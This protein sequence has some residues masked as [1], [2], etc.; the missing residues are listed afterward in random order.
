MCGR[1]ILESSPHEVK[2]YFGYDETPNFPPRYNI[3][4]TQPIAVIC[5]H[6]NRP[7]F[8]LMKW[9]FLPGWV[10]DPKDFPL[11]INARSETA[12]EKPAFRAAI[13]YRRCL[14]PVNGFYEWL[15]EGK[16]KY[17]YYAKSTTGVIG[18]AG[19]WEHWMAAD[20]SEVDTVAFLTTQANATLSAIHHRMPIVIKREDFDLWLDP[21]HHE[22]KSALALMKAPEEEQFDLY[23]V[24]QKVNS[25][26]NQGADLI[27]RLLI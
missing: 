24:S 14:I 3:A 27:D 20:G 8:Q 16:D 4:P 15:R 2:A 5:H 25:A 9:G 7:S 6:D 1:F 11:L 23:P 22:L 10:K 13:K 18:L 12:V 26:R 21:S 17:P 19:I